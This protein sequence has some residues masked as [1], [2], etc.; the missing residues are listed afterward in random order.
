MSHPAVGTGPVDVANPRRYAPH[1]DLAD[2]LAQRGPLTAAQIAYELNVPTRDA[3]ATLNL[4][5]RDPHVFDSTAEPD[6]E[7]LLAA[8]IAICRRADGTAEVMR[9]REGPVP[10]PVSDDEIEILV[11]GERVQRIVPNDGAGKSC[12]AEWRLKGMDE[13]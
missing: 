13:Q 4:L 1:L 11:S 8:D 6:R 5:R 3:L 10:R 9:D 2:L 12:P 7:Q